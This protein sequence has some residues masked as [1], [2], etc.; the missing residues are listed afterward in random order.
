MDRRNF[1]FIY[2]FCQITAVDCTWAQWGTWGQC[3]KTCGDGSSKQRTRIKTRVEENGGTCNG[4]PTE[5]EQDCSYDWGTNGC[6]LQRKK[7]SNTIK[8]IWVKF[9][10]ENYENEGPYLNCVRFSIAT[11]FDGIKHQ[12]ETETDCGGTCEPCYSGTS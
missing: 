4:Q 6:P 10:L 8:A 11:C 5:T 3:S 12:G 2:C 1:C 7:N 9:N